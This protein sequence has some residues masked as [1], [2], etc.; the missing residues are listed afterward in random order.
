MGFN[1][2]FKGLRDINGLSKAYMHRDRKGSNQSTVVFIQYG[3]TGVAT[4]DSEQLSTAIRPLRRKTGKEINKNIDVEQ[5][6][7]NL[8]CYINRDKDT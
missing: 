2:G 5:T 6:K 1:S 4:G 8:Q 3:E 7:Y